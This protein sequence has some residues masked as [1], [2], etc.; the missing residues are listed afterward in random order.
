MIYC[1]TKDDD[2]WWWR[3]GSLGIQLTSA[4]WSV[5]NIY[6]HITHWKHKICHWMLVLLYIFIR[7]QNMQQ[8]KL[9]KNTKY[10]TS[11]SWYFYTY[12]FV[13][14]T[15]NKL[16]LYIA[17][18]IISIPF[19]YSSIPKHIQTTR[20][21]EQQINILRDDLWSQVF[22]WAHEIAN[23]TPAGRLIAHELSILI[24]YS[25]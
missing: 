13:C 7:I 25:V 6:H 24:L 22:L 1:H 5:S 21:R 15:C 10:V 9:T 12:S 16:D 23:S 19:R 4:K 17:A 20:Q 8:V 2:E 11:E 3:I 18:Y 14:K